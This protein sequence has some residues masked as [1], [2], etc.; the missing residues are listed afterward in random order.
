LHTL[1]AARFWKRPAGQLAQTAAPAGVPVPAWHALQEVEPVSGLDLPAAHA[2]QAEPA[3]PEDVPRGQAVHEVAEV[4][5]GLL[6][7]PAGQA[8]HAARLPAVV[9]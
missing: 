2:R 4:A 5:P 9:A 8:V 7:R 3:K 6:V 1:C